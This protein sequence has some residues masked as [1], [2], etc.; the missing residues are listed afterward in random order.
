[1]ITKDTD[2]QESHLL[3]GSPERLLRVA[4]GNIKNADLISLFTRLLPV[5]E[6]AFSEANFVDLSASGLTIHTRLNR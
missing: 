4:T 3:D 1:M 5:L 2:F 6:T